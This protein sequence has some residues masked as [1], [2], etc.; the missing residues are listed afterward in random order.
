NIGSNFLLDGIDDN[1]EIN[2]KAK[3]EV[4]A[5]LR[6]T[7][8]PEFLNRLDEIV[9][10]KPLAQKDVVKIVELM[11]TNVALRLKELQLRLTVTDEAKNVIANTAYEPQFGAR[12]LKRFIQAKIE[13]LI[14]KYL[15]S[16]EIQANTLI[17]V[18]F[19]DGEFTINLK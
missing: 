4:Q 18:G 14:A 19:K 8:R 15:L 12:P 6:I 1:G 10:F 16:K 9:F 13:T 11:L 7:F 17:E 3:D 5:L 2:E